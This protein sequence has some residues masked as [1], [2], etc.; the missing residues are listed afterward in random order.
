MK[1]I[2]GNRIPGVGID[3]PGVLQVSI[4][5]LL[6]GDFLHRDIIQFLH[7]E[8]AC[9]VGRKHSGHQVTGGSGN[10]GKGLLMRSV[11][12]SLSRNIDR[13]PTRRGVLLRNHNVLQ[14]FSKTLFI[15]LHSPTLN[16]IRKPNVEACPPGGVDRQK[17]DVPSSGD[18]T[19]T[20]GELGD[21]ASTTT[22]P[23]TVVLGLLLPHHR[24][25]L[26]RLGSTID[27]LTIRGHTLA[28]VPLCRMQAEVKFLVTSQKVIIRVHRGDNDIFVLDLR[29]QGGEEVVFQIIQPLHRPLVPG[30]FRQPRIHRG[31]ID[32]SCQRGT[33][34]R[35]SVL[36]QNL[37][38]IPFL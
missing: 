31:L 35:R 21:P 16:V 12:V 15:Q 36:S 28:K 23:V 1:I 25:S 3:E 17:S 8:H 30:L 4:H 20:K 37:R 22:E 6:T 2:K 27:H 14:V 13:V 10:I 26:K 11:V 32:R 18:T 5:P 38:I 34:C 33:I 29:I 24:K 9:L 19:K 7:G